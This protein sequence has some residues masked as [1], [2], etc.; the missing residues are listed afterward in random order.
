MSTR[1]RR[2]TA[3]L[4]T[5]ALSLAFAVPAL[6]WDVPQLQLTADYKKSSGVITVYYTVAPIQGLESA[7]FR[8]RYQSDKVEF[9][10]GETHNVTSDTVM[11]F[12]DDKPEQVIRLQYVEL[13]HVSEENC[14]EN[15]AMIM[16]AKFKVKD[17][18]ATT[19]S[20]TAFT[21]S[22]AMDPDSHD[23]IPDRFT[24]KLDLTKDQKAGAET[25]GESNS[26]IWV[27][28]IA[29]VLSAV[30]LG[31]AVVLFV[32]KVN[33]SEPEPQKKKQKPKKK[34]EPDSFAIEDKAKKAAKEPLEEPQD[35]FIFDPDAD[36]SDY[37]SD[38]FED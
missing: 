38:K 21:E 36:L 14:P 28:V 25:G 33:K 24:L 6:A 26:K 32:R 30:V 17:K 16:T 7:D 9:V 29:A 37:N 12:S 15:T 10:S 35:P 31:L 2:L 13:Y 3:L 34:P 5:L 8:L 18:N 19:A 23:E 27:I 1:V 20:F 4:L 11:D 22:C